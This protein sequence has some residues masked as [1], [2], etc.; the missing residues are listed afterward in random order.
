MMLTLKG[1]LNW[2]KDWNERNRRKAK[3]YIAKKWSS[4]RK[5]MTAT[6]VT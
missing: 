3:R 6:H 2:M 5:E 4:V 1:S